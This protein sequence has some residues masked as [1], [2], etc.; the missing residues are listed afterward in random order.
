MGAT[1]SLRIFLKRVWYDRVQFDVLVTTRLLVPVFLSQGTL[2]SR[3]NT[4]VGFRSI[5]TSVG[6]G[7]GLLVLLMGVLSHQ[8]TSLPSFSLL[9]V[10]RIHAS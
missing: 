9:C 10:V 4:W 3:P 5:F 6:V 2:R 8:G 1:K 7:F